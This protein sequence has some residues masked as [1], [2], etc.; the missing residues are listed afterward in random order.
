MTLIA[1]AAMTLLAI[2]GTGHGETQ[3]AEPAPPSSELAVRLGNASNQPDG[4]WGPVTLGLNARHA[5]G[6]ALTI[7]ASYVR[8]HEPHAPA[9]VSHVDEARVTTAIPHLHFGG[10][11][12]EIAATAWE[13]RL[14]DMYTD[15]GGLQI[16]KEGAVSLLAGLYGGR[17]SRGDVR[18]GFFGGQLAVSG[19][20][21][22]LEWSLSYVDG[23]IVSPAT[24]FWAG[25][26]HHA[27]ADL[28]WNTS[29]ARW[30]PLT[31]AV[32]IEERAFNFG[33]GGPSSAREDEW[34][35]VA[36]L[37]WSLGPLLGLE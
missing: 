4:L 9:T 18:G 8:L 35:F 3:E 31:I 1:V 12:F 17:A 19:P 20:V 2:A 34:I 24:G 14:I 23:N 37:E 22:P 10:K 5:F 25:K 29:P 26:Y 16:T 33:P 7:E 27:E 13:N 15:L 32:D 21:G 36:G 6:Q 11:M 30:L 28:T